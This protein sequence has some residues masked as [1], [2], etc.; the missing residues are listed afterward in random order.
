MHSAKKNINELNIGFQDAAQQLT[1][2]VSYVKCRN[3]RNCDK[4]IRNS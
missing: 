2:I 1:E 4:A 3:E